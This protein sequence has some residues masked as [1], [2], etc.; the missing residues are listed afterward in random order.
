MAKKKTSSP[1]VLKIIQRLKKKIPNAACALQFANPLELL[2][3]TILSA[4]CTDARVNVVTQTLFQ[5]YRH[6][7]DYVRTKPEELEQDIKSTGFY[8]NKTKSIQG[9]C[10]SIIENFEGQVPNTMEELT[11]LPGVAR[12]TANVVLGNAYD[13]AEGVVVDTHVLRL[14]QRM[15]LTQERTPEKIEVDLMGIVPRKDWIL[16]GHLMTHHG[17]LT[18]QARKPLC[19][20]CVLKDICPKI[21][22][23]PKLTNKVSTS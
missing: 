6:P 20:E 4:Q 12:K 2:V 7:Q 17:R 15:G 8:R 9:A 21:G 19:P 14:T 3:A 22:V 11:T 13:I 10:K 18:C 5:K 23:N 1:E 16:F